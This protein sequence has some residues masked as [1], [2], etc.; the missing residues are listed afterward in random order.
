MELADHT[1]SFQMPPRSSTM[2][3][4]HSHIQQTGYYFTNADL[5]R[6]EDGIPDCADFS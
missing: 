1:T 5:Y 4:A 2:S 3:V 6:A